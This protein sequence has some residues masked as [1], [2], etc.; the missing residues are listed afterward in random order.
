MLRFCFRAIILS[1]G[2][3]SVNEAEAL[4]YDDRIFKA[5]I[6]ILGICYGLHLINKQFGGTVE[7]KCFREDGQYEVDFDTSSP[8]FRLVA[9]LRILYHCGDCP[10]HLPHPRRCLQ[11]LRIGRAVESF[12]RLLK[13]F[14]SVVLVRQSVPCLYLSK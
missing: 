11:T 10:R 7:Q 13:S 5:N 2:P 8:L 9:A 3:Q 1:G 6:P 12:I 4:K 14:V